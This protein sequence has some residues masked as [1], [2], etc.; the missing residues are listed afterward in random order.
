MFTTESI[1]TQFIFKEKHKL[2][3]SDVRHEKKKKKQKKVQ[4]G[5]GGESTEDEDGGIKNM[6][7]VK[8]KH[9]SV[10]KLK[11]CKVEV[12]DTDTEDDSPDSSSSSEKKVVVVK[13]KRFKKKMN[14]T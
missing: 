7:Y 13:R 11:N 14:K 12:S 9:K 6:E 4:E 2:S 3:D 8:A 5:D 10:K 1:I